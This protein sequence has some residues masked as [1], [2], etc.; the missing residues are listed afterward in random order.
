VQS[1]RERLPEIAATPAILLG[2]L[3]GPEGNPLAD[4]LWFHLGHRLAALTPRPGDLIS[5]TGRVA[6]Y[7]RRRKHWHEEAIRYD[8]DL[9]TGP[10]EPLRP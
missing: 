10:P 2:P 5:L 6:R 8:D 1:P 9:D 7:H 3:H 4:P